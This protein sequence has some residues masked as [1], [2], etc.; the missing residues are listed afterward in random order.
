MNEREFG[1]WR[2]TKIWSSSS[3]RTRRRYERVSETEAVVV[4]ARS[5][6]LLYS[7]SS[8]MPPSLPLSHLTHSHT[9]AHSPR[10]H[11]LAHDGLDSLG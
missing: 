11:S 9:L 4:F 5:S 6:R 3:S 1:G 7:G 2:H 8:L 10:S